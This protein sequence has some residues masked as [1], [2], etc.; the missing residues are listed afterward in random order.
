MFVLLFNNC[1]HY[2]K[3]KFLFVAMSVV[4]N[5]CD[6]SLYQRAVA[7]DRGVEFAHSLGAMFTETSAADNVG[8]HVL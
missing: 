1:L 7:T 2:F 4:G 5:K 3:C 8:K 6:L